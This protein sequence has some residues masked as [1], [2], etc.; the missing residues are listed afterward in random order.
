MGK[1]PDYPCDFCHMPIDQNVDDS[2]FRVNLFALE[3]RAERHQVGMWHIC[4]QCVK[5]IVDMIQEDGK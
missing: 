2:M 5:M 3:L 4:P 1:I